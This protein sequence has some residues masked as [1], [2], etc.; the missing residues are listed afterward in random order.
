LLAGRQMSHVAEARARRRA[1][2][3]KYFSQSACADEGVCLE[4]R[5][6]R[7]TGDTAVREGEAKLSGVMQ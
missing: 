5:L 2:F 4:S 6:F 7:A 3:S 1:G